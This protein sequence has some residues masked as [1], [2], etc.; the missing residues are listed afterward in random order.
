MGHITVMTQCHARW[1]G[2]AWRHW[3]WRHSDPD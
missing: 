1:L 3:G 2:N